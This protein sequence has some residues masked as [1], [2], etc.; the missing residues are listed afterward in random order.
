MARISAREAIHKLA[1]CSCV[2]GPLTRRV[3][4]GLD[5][6]LYFDPLCGFVVKTPA[7]ISEILD[8]DVYRSCNGIGSLIYC[9]K[10]DVRIRIRSD[11]PKLSD[12][13]IVLLEFYELLLSL[14][15]QAHEQSIATK[16]KIVPGHGH[17]SNK[18]PMFLDI[19]QIVHYICKDITDLSSAK[20]DNRV[21]QR[22]L[23]ILIRIL[24]HSMTCMFRLKNES[25]IVPYLKE[26]TKEKEVI[27][28]AIVTLMSISHRKLSPLDVIP[29]LLGSTTTTTS[30]NDNYHNLSL[31]SSIDT[32]SI[33][34]SEI[35]MKFI[36]NVDA[37]YDLFGLTKCEMLCECSKADVICRVAQVSIRR[38]HR[39]LGISEENLVTY[40]DGKILARITRS[41]FFGRSDCMRDS[42]ALTRKSALPEDSPWRKVPCRV[43]GS[44]RVISL[45]KF[46]QVSSC[47]LDDFLPIVH[48]L[49]DE[50][51]SDLRI[52]GS[53]ALIHLLRQ[54]T[55]TEI[56][57]RFT[58]T[59][60]V[61]SIACRANRDASVSSVLALSRY[62][63]FR[64]CSSRVKIYDD[65]RKT[66]TEMLSIVS[67]CYDSRPDNALALLIGGATPLFATLAHKDTPELIEI[68]RPCLGSLLPIIK[69]GGIS[70]GAP[71]I[72]ASLS[73][74]V[75]L[76]TGSWPIIG[77]YSKKIM[78]ALLLC[79]GE[80]KRTIKAFSVYDLECKEQINER[81][82]NPAHIDEVGKYIISL[83][84]Y[85]G[86]ITVIACGE[87]SLE[88]LSIA[89][90]DC[91]G[92]IVEVC[93]DIRSQ[94]SRVCR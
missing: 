2:S 7:V 60:Q 21:H 82:V 68:V 44:I 8:C 80:C 45:F 25:G 24:T 32:T 76:I 41:Y 40:I 64:V 81:K 54:A 27:S 23:P 67:I 86:A 12:S 69:S 6:D 37:F 87:S 51:L 58:L 20:G 79:T 31:K 43:H 34:A 10:D 11:Q 13:S 74:L 77:K 5:G 62:E 84:T 91:T 73:C 17:L 30:D 42:E 65:I 38:L 4:E 52:M 56:M 55:S 94:A 33:T 3:D 85:V 89:E 48:S 66:L 19:I 39:E 18:D 47:V 36:Q 22:I 46:P 28:I 75:S 57:E 59:N 9:Y 1:D 71:I 63:L 61:L 15:L 35:S 72:I 83:A 53:C 16:S 78:T 29:S 50:S 70:Y 90:K 92:E 14:S 93:R 49:I 88:V 26:E